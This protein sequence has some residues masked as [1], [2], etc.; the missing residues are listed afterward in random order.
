MKTL[1]PI[2][3]LAA[4]IASSASFAQT[5]AFSKPSGYTTQLLRPNTIN[6]VGLNVLTPTVAAGAITSFQ[7]SIPAVTDSAANFNTTLEA[8]KMYT[9]EITSGPAIGSIREF[10]HSS[11]NTRLTIS[12]A[13]SGLLAGDK[14]IIRKN[15]TLQELF[16][17]GAP[18]TGAATSPGTADI[19]RVPD[20]LGNFTQYWYKTGTTSGAIGWWTTPNGTSR[21]A[22]VTTDIP[23]LYTD[24]I[25]IQRRAGVN[26]NLVLTGQVKTTSSRVYVVTGSNPVSINP[27]AGS[28]LANS[29]L[30]L[31]LRGHG[32]SPATADILWVRNASGTSFS[33]YWRKT[34][35]TGGNIGWYLTPDGV[36]PGTIVNAGRVNLSPY[37]LIERKGGARFMEVKVPPFYSN[38]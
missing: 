10:I 9:I 25:Q 13:I 1:I 17:A 23:L 32:T 21:G 2:T 22:L 7:N 20:G 26:K 4:L 34:S 27:P 24:G 3:A 19:V 37:C 8:G 14:Y 31:S 16:P 29:E 11:N 18:L 33:R 12:T 30:S 5:P 36:A 28:T 15:L 6:Y 38:L 35:T